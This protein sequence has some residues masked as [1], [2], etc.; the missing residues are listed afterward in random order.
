MKHYLVIAVVI[1][2]VLSFSGAASG[3]DYSGQYLGTFLLPDYH[4]TTE[5]AA[6]QGYLDD[7]AIDDEVVFYT[8]INFDYNSTEG[9]LS[10][11]DPIDYYGVKAGEDIAYFALGDP[12][13]AIE[14][15]TIF[16]GGY[17]QPAISH[18]SAWT[19][20]PPDPP[21]VPESSTVVIWSLLGISWAGVSVWRRRR[22]AAGRRP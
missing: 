15:S 16:N 6:L 2:G 21:V 14:W 13:T 11:L 5:T 19:V 3:I 8:K 4:W 18:L 22:I 17:T 9:M 7:E 1:A 12:V 20:P 10:F